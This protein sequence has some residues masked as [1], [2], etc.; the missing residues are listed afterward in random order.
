MKMSKIFLA[1]I[2]PIASKNIEIKGIR[3]KNY[4]KCI[5]LNVFGIKLVININE[6]VCG[7]CYN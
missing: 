6:N 5:I 4:E 1:L 7:T 3:G 2:S